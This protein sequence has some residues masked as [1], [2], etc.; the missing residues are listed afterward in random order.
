MRNKLKAKYG[1]PYLDEELLG[2]FQNELVLIGARSGAGK[3]TIANQIAIHNSHKL[4]V[5]LFSLENFDGDLLDFETFKEYK[6]LN[7]ACRITFR[8]FCNMEEDEHFPIAK[9]KASAKIDKMSVVFRKVD[10][11]NINDMVENFLKLARE[12]CE[13][14]IIDHID[15]FDMH[16]PRENENKNISDIMKE[17]RKLQ[18][19][20]S[21]PV[22]M[23]SHLRKGIKETII[24]TLED[25]MGTSN[26][27]KEA[28]TVILF[29]PDD[30]ENSSAEI[31]GK[32]KKSTWVC[33]RKDR[34]NGYRD[35][36]CK[37]MFDPSTLS[38]EEEY[39]LYSVNYWGTKVEMI[40]GSEEKEMGKEIDRI[41]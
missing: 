5:A 32:H 25:F 27:V 21:V 4:K 37:V 35:K 33:I 1:I 34:M 3:T 30:E 10:G 29:S 14:F 16:N 2:I 9:S 41:M 18:D 31:S 40:P 23:I 7:L 17:V 6:K 13:L 38:Y 19:I 28:T 24:P 36:V 15:Y 11:F 8:D 22:I 26:K 20:Y 12:G 39:R